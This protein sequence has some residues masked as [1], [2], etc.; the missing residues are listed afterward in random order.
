MTMRL[1][2]GASKSPE[3]ICKSHA[4]CGYCF[5]YFI[6]SEK[7]S[8]ARVSEH[9]RRYIYIYLYLYIHICVHVYMYMNIRVRV[10]DLGATMLGLLWLIT[11]VSQSNLEARNYNNCKTSNNNK[12]DKPSTRSKNFAAYLKVNTC[13]E[14]FTRNFP[15]SLCSTCAAEQTHP[16]AA[17]IGMFSHNVLLACACPMGAHF[18]AFLL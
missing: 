11:P 6:P 1:K 12:S 3:S 17:A 5:G 16:A 14:T 13:T 4:F 9:A 8:Y 2:I 7:T 10:Y 15:V 18:R